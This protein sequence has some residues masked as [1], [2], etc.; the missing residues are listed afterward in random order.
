MRGDGGGSVGLV[1]CEGFGRWCGISGVG[2]CGESGAEGEEEGR[3]ERGGLPLCFEDGS[4]DCSGEHVGGILIVYSAD[5]VLMRSLVSVVL[6]FLT[7]AL[8]STLSPKRD[9]V[10]PAKTGPN[11]L[12]VAAKVPTPAALT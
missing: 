8:S 5:M 1:G 7:L 9:S 3:W 10:K 12:N 6:Y 4:F 11:F 2:G